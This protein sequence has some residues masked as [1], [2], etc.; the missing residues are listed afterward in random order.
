METIK[1]FRMIPSIEKLLQRK[2]VRL[3]EVRFGYDVVVHALR[4]ETELMRINLENKTAKKNNRNEITHQIEKGLAKRLHAMLSPS[5]RPVINAT[6]TIIHT[7]LGRAPLAFPAIKKIES[8]AGYSNLEFDLELGK[9]GSR[10][11]HALKLLQ[12]L[13]GAEDGAVVNNNAAAVLLTLTALAAGK[14]VIISRGELV[15]IGGGFRIPDVLQQAGAHLREIGTTNR[16]RSSDYAS[17]I[18]DQTALILRIN[19]SN[20]RIEGFTERPP[21][22]E[23]IDIGQRF[24]IPVIEDLGSGNVINQHS[25]FTSGQ[26]K[27]EEPTV[28]SSVTAGVT[29]CCFSGDKLLGGPQAGI[30]VGK[31][32]EV[33]K[34]RRHPLMRALRIDKIIYA[35]LE[36]TLL[37]HVTGR[38]SQTVPIVAM[39]SKSVES[40]QSRAKKIVDTLSNNK[41]LALTIELNQ[42]VIGGGTT[43]GVQVPS[44]V[45]KVQLDGCSPDKLES[46]LRQTTPPI[47]GRIN[48]DCVLLDLR[49]VQPNEDNDLTNALKELVS[50]HAE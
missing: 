30:I 45:L 7:N 42:S 25:L 39:I 50:I 4:E 35:A 19:P 33:E 26:Q 23:I 12:H 3:L 8:V 46:L 22:N 41:S 18:N 17:A 49:T 27:W 2:T 48:K 15:E 29:V 24:K 36:A 6:G 47:I 38:A 14:E 10:T 40:L 31:S 9:R 37:E 43:P 32:T 13:T 21:L 28:N 1:Q 20:F 34:I 5:L 44:C 16:T 11:I